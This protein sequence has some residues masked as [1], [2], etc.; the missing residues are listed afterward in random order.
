MVLVA[1]GAQSAQLDATYFLKVPLTSDSVPSALLAPTVTK[2]AVHARVVRGVGTALSVAYTLKASALIVQEVASVL[3]Q[4]L[5]PPG[6][7]RYAP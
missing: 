6:D 3:A 5:L 4:E 7:A 2:I 1:T